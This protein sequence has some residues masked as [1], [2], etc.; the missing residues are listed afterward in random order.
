VFFKTDAT[1]RHELLERAVAAI[2]SAAY[3]RGQ[4][5]VAAQKQLVPDQFRE[6]EFLGTLKVGA[7]ELYSILGM[8]SRAM[9][10]I[11]PHADRP[12]C[13]VRGGCGVGLF[14]SRRH[15]MAVSLVVAHETVEETAALALLGDWLGFTVRGQILLDKQ[16]H[17]VRIRA[18]EEPSIGDA[19]F[20]LPVI[21][22]PS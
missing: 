2:E 19:H 13:V 8:L 9:A 17:R 22:L 5:I 20:E 14:W 21:K 16:M 3:S 1:L 10:P 11:A 6:H 7:E 12:H 15:G 4:S 18:F